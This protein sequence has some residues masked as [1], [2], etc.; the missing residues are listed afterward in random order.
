MKKLDV[1]N[2]IVLI[3]GAGSGI[4]QE[5]A[6]KFAQ[7]GAYVIITDINQAGLDKTEHLIV[8]AGGRCEKHSVDVTSKA[9]MKALAAK[10]EETHGALTVLINN[11]GVLVI[12]PLLATSESSWDKLIDVNIRGVI[13]GSEAFIPAMMRAGKPAAVVNL[14]ST[15]SFF[16]PRDMA[17]YSVTKFA[18]LSYSEGL[19]AELEDYNISVSAICPGIIKTP[20]IQS[21]IMEGDL[22]E[23]NAKDRIDQMYI[24]RNYG[25]DKVAK[26]IYNA[27]I[28]RKKVVPVSIEAWLAYYA[29]RFV[30]AIMAKIGRVRAVK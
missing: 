27:T 28:K 12:G 21:T 2:K 20:L 9:Q 24:K 7:Q 29:K 6:I 5:T 8:Q 17:A 1:N 25:P 26:A 13:N 19:R 23:N 11:A 10:V 4:G 22:A 15:A 14:A 18:V 30:P 3:T 16:A